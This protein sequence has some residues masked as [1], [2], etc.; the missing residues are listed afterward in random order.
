MRDSLDLD[1]YPLDRPDR[2][3]WRALVSECRAGLRA[4]GVVNLPGFLREAAVAEAVRGLAPVFAEGAF[5][6]VRRHN[7][8]FG[9]AVDGLDAA[10]PA[11]RLFETANR[12]VCA[13][14][15]AGSPLLRLYDWPPM[16]AFLA[17]VMEKPALFPM[18]DPLARVNAMAY[19][20]GQQLGWHFDRSEFTTTLLLQ[21][22]EGG[23]AFEYDTD[24]RS[25]TNPNYE[26][27]A[28]LL[29]GR[30]RP[31]RMTLAPGALNIFRGRNT[32]HR[33]TPVEGAAERIIAVLSYFDR[34]GV[35][36]SEAERVGFYGRAA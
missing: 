5:A 27:V 23:G 6:H 11:L 1:R 35:T 25:E 8:Y 32:A 15:M 19:S 26:G 36:F 21:A 16:A 3:G 14:Q 29:E 17:A 30:R 18:A 33:V 10:H 2:E 12:T 34:P 9:P 24:L 20:E 31:K 4:D 22:P 7:I 28:D 13:D